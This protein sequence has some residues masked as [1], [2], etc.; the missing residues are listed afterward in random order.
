LVARAI[1]DTAH[2]KYIN[3]KVPKKT[4]IFNEL[5]IDW[6]KEL[7]L[8]EGPFDLI[9]AT[10]NATCLLGS[11][12]SVGSHLF[13]QITK[14]CTPVVL[15]LDPDAILKTHDI[16]KK[17]ADFGVPVGLVLPDAFGDMEDVGAMSKAK[18]KDLANN[19]VPWTPIQRIA[20]KIGQIRSG[21]LL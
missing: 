9:K 2:R 14:N 16:A 6:K 13:K 8:V 21:S 4:V 1:D 12:L 15:A 3:A 7:V 17:L 10:H 11:S 18:F 19:A 5:N 20:T